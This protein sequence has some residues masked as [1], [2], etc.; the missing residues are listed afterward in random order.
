MTEIVP[1]SVIN[2][3]LK[4][5]E[6]IDSYSSTLNLATQLNKMID[7]TKHIVK[8]IL[9]APTTSYKSVIASELNTVGQIMQCCSHMGYINTSKIIDDVMDTNSV[10]SDYDTSEVRDTSQPSNSSYNVGGGLFG[11]TKNENGKSEAPQPPAPSFNVGGGLFGNTKN[12]N[13]KSEAP[14]PP[15]PSFNVG[16]GL[17]G[18]TAKLLNLQ[19]H[20]LAWVEDYLVIRMRIRTAKL[21]NLQLHHLL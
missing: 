15:A 20:H 8:D 16:G 10:N 3:H 21:L 6:I 19:L 12:E 13:G 4:C 17:F 11:N 18:N 2:R 5:E 9:D 1:D 14:Q 7:E